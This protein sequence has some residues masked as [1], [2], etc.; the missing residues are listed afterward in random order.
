MG[1]KFYI[2]QIVTTIVL[3]YTLDLHKG[4]SLFQMYMLHCN[5]MLL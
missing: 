1:F 2:I 3:K 4:C 5:T